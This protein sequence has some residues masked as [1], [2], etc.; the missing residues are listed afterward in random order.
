MRS[1][2]TTYQELFIG[3]VGTSR[4]DK[5]VNICSDTSKCCLDTGIYPRNDYW[6][7]HQVTKFNCD[8]P[9]QMSIDWLGMAHLEH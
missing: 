9:A 7:L 3:R 5:V 8:E 1:T 4:R 6:M 2:H